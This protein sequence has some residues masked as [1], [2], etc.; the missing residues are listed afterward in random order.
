MGYLK[1]IMALWPYLKEWFFGG[2]TVAEAYRDDKR[3][4]IGVF[5]LLGVLVFA[6][7]LSSRLYTLSV[8]KRDMVANCPPEEVKSSNLPGASVN[9]AMKDIA[10][11]LACQEDPKECDTP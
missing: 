10:V 3:Y 9:E 7:W 1:V 6:G 8:E 2:K 5:V 11:Y 4:T